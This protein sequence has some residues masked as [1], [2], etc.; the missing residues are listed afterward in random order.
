M[1]V[2]LIVAACTAADPEGDAS[3]PSTFAATSSTRPPTTTSSP[4]TTTTRPPSG[5]GP[6]GIAVVADD[7]APPTLNLW[8]PGGDN[9]IVWVIA[10][11]WIPRA[12]DVEAGT[13]ELIPDVLVE[14]PRVSNG[15]VEV[16]EDGRTTVRYRIRDEARWSDGTRISGADFAYTL[17]VGLAADASDELPDQGYEDLD[18]I[19]TEVGD[20]TFT[21]TMRRPT[22]AYEQAFAWLLPAHAL[23]DTDF[24][25]AWSDGGWLSGGPF[26]IDSHEP[27]QRLSLVRNDAYGKVDADGRSLP[28]LDGVEFVFIPET[29]ELMRA[30]GAREVDVINPPPSISTIEALQALESDGVDVQFRNGPVWEH[31]NFQFGPGRL[32]LAPDSCNDN[33]AFRRAVMHAIDRDTVIEDY[34]R[35]HAEP[36]G[37]YLDAFTPGLATPAWDRYPYDPDQARLLYEQAVT[38]TGR[39]CAAVFSTTSNSDMRPHFANAYSE[40]F[41]AAGI[42]MEL[43]LMD[44]QMF[45][46]DALDD[47][48]WDI[49]QWAWVGS[50]GLYGAADIH[51]IFDPGAPPP[52][53][54]NYY[55]WGTRGSAVRDEYTERFAEI[56][57]DMATT[58]DDARIRDLI[59]EAEGI[60]AD[61]A[62]ILPMQS[63]LTVGAVW[64][65]EIGGYE[66]NQPGRAHL[67]HRVVVPDGPVRVQVSRS[68]RYSSSSVPSVHFASAQTKIDTAVTTIATT[69]MPMLA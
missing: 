54:D 14:I 67:E 50:P 45:F 3:A 57:D 38:E 25:S 63:R 61:Q 13:L 15:G 26:E 62:I 20:T 2:A 19:A 51:R 46:G 22:I 41:E 42:P 9:F 1:A 68:S 56:V 8:L 30:F 32:D 35:G 33:L 60:L 52:D 11:A 49:G 31:I 24:P 55:R 36:L 64:A 27:F 23:A 21:M 4:S 44:S 59:T 48:T 29:E 37:S 65:D 7:Q 18:I 66:Y 16:A 17:D 12:W 69:T 28:Y 5:P 34:Y 58:V 39:D 47:G 6:G 53:G 10:Q 40:M 43:E